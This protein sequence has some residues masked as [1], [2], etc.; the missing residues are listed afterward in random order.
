MKTKK[1]KKREEKHNRVVELFRELDGIGGSRMAMWQ[2]MEKRTGYSRQ[3]ITKVLRE[4]GIN[5][6]KKRGNEQFENSI[7]ASAQLQGHP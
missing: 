3:Y 1:Q 7:N 2:E 5:Y 4:N 6:Q